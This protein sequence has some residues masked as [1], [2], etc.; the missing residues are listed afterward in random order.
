MDF[1]TIDF[2][3]WLLDCPKY[4]NSMT[5]DEKEIEIN[6]FLKGEGITI[7]QLCGDVKQ[8]EKLP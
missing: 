8:L 3:W 5:Y 2:V 6:K 4:P 1:Q 7:A